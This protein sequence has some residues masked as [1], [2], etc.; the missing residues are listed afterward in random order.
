MRRDVTLRGIVKAKAGGVHLVQVVLAIQANEKA[1]RYRLG[2]QLIRV[3][4]TQSKLSI[5]TSRQVDRRASPWHYRFPIA[6]GVLTQRVTPSEGCP[7]HPW[8]IRRRHKDCMC[9]LVCGPRI[10]IISRPPTLKG[11]QFSLDYSRVVCR[12]RSVRRTLKPQR[13]GEQVSSYR[14][15]DR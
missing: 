15:D 7:T 13:C 1:R 12:S 8:R 2:S 11:R 4:A 5:V 14:R 6:N 10:T 9:A 3:L